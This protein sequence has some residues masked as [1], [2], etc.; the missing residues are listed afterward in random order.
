LLSPL[1]STLVSAVTTSAPLSPQLFNSIASLFRLPPPPSFLFPLPAISAPL[2]LSCKASL[3]VLKT[4]KENTLH[5]NETSVELGKQ[6]KK[7]ITFLKRPHLNCSSLSSSIISTASE[8]PS[9]P[10]TS[11]ELFSSLARPSELSRLFFTPYAGLAYCLLAA[12]AA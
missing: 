5:E 2:R 1:V 10:A 9:L 11:P 3:Q 8:F 4:H 7:S 12:I 6:R